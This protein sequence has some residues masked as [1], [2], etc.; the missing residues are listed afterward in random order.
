[1]VS[2]IGVDLVEER[3]G[4]EQEISFALEDIKGLLRDQNDY[5]QRIARV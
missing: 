2:R 3:P 1:M 5:L 4:L